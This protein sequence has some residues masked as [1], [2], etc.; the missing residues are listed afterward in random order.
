MT[1]KPKRSQR[2]KLWKVHFQS[3]KYSGEY[4]DVTVSAPNAR[5][6]IDRA[7]KIT[8][9][10]NK[11]DKRKSVESVDLIGVSEN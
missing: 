8:Y 2:V 5:C 10:G 7:C 4:E 6:A 3:L 9:V 11:R 1:N